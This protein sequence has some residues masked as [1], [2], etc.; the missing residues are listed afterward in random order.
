MSSSFNELLTTNQTKVSINIAKHLFLK[1]SN[2]NKNIVFSPL[3]LQF[4][5]SLIAAGSEGPTKQ[6]LLNFLLSKSSDDLND[7]ASHLVSDT[8]NDA[9]PAGGPRL[10]FLDGLFV[11]QTFPLQDSFK[12]IVS[13]NY[14]TILASYDFKNQ[15]EEAVKAVN[16]WVEKKTNCLI[17][18][19]LPPRLNDPNTGLIFANALFFKGA[20]DQ[21]F[22][23]SKT[24]DYD[25]HLLNGRSVK[26]PFM[27]TMEKQC[28]Q[29]FSDFKVLRLPYKKGGED[30]RRFSMYLFLPNA[31]DGLSALVKRLTSTPNLL[32]N[33]LNSRLEV[34]DCRIPKFNISFG[35]EATDM[36]KDLGVDLPFSPKTVNSDVGHGLFVS[37]IFHKSFFKVEEEKEEGTEAAATSDAGFSYKCARPRSRLDFVADH[38]FL[39]LIREDLKEEILFIGQVLNPLAR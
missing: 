16:L 12:Q 34:R 19:L 30:K 27:I 39:F 36:L 28:I 20:W 38:P 2:K 29:T 6:Q 23:V 32:R 33:F 14:K 10:S 7:F 37:N 21:K 3:F 25:F 9:A 18:E 24:K 17:K 26:V 13:K 1:E 11:E 8:L 4:V 35:F 5:L 31:K 15:A 22:D